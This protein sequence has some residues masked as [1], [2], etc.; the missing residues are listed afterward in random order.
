MKNKSRLWGFL[1]AFIALLLATCLLPPLSKPKARPSRIQTVNYVASVSF[2][3]PGT[4]GLPAAK[5]SR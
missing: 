5:Q 1:I 4:N 2:T 3:I